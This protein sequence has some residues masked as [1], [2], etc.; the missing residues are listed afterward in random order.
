MYRT[1]DQVA[2]EFIAEGERQGVTRRGIIMCIACG[3]VESR[4]RVLANP[5][6]P[7]SLRLPN[8]GQGTDG[9]SV[10]PLQQQIVL[11]PRGYW[12]A[13]ARTCM[14]PTTSS[15]LFYERLRKI[16]Y[17]NEARSP[18][19]YVQDIQ[20]SA[21]PDR[22]D[23]RMAE[24]TAIYNRLKG[25]PPMGDPVWLA[26]VLRAEGLAVEEYPNW[27]DRG[28]GDFGEIGWVVA[29][30]TGGAASARSIAEHPELGLCSQIFL[31]K[32]V[33]AH[34]VG[35]GIAWHGGPGEYPGIPRNDVNRVSIGIEAEN[36]GTEGWSPAQYWAYVKVCAAICR[37]LG[38]RADRVIGHKEW[39]GKAQGKWDPGGIDMNAFRRDIQAQIDAGPRPAPPPVTNQIDEMQKI[40]GFWLGARDGKLGE[41]KV[42][43]A[44]GKGR[45]AKFANGYIYWS[46]ATGARA[47]PNRI[48][49]YW[50]STGWEKGPLG[51][52]IRNHT[53]VDG[54]GEIQAFKNGVVLRKLGD[55]PGANVHGIIG[56][57]YYKRGAEK[58]PELGWPVGDEYDYLGGRA[59]DFENGTLVWHPSG[60][61][62]IT[63]E[64]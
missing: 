41:E 6:V 62:I 34:T 29:H 51:Y 21:F 9:F 44:D 1:A 26:Q 63:K 5:K 7:E 4:L 10:G 30:H 13:D 56:D 20:S 43:G 48:F 55:H 8:D 23:E 59:Q 38:L 64:K 37:K 45:Y 31:D 22:Y 49:E 24:A 40:A 39:A 17:N 46:E 25:G 54:V 52:P 33:V 61:I 27:L 47:V 14:D 58:N 28:H 42:C 19:R 36:N 16:D 11:T 53:Y 57:S 32:R 18:G 3:L 60:A 2:L 12:W 35:A 50:A 15:R